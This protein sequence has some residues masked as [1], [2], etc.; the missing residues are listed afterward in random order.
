MPSPFRLTPRTFFVRHIT[1]WALIFCLIAPTL[2]TFAETPASP[3]APA[4]MVWEY[5]FTEDPEQAD[6]CRRS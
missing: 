1:G 6:Y 3:P 2:T 5:L 4:E